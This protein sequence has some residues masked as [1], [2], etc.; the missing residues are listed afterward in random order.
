MKNIVVYSPS[1]FS[2]EIWL[3]TLWSQAKTYYELN[4]KQ[5]D[6]WHWYPCYADMYADDSTKVKEIIRQANPAVFAISLYV[7][8]AHT[9]FSIAKWVKKTFP[10]CIV[11][12]GG[13]Q[14]NFLYDATWFQK[15]PYIDA[16]LPGE[17]YGELF[18]QQLL[19]NYSNG[20]VDWNQVSDARYP[21]GASRQLFTSALHLG[22]QEKKQFDYNWPSFADQQDNID[23]FV[24]YKNTNFPS[25]KLLAV[26]ETTR[27]CPYG[28]TYCDW[29]GGIATTVIKK[30]KQSVD[31]DLEL[32][33]SLDLKY[34]YIA[35]ANFGIFGQRDVDIIQTLVHYRTQFSSNV[36]IGY[37]GFAKT[38][39]KMEYI[40]KILEIDLEHGL[41]SSN[42]IK[43]SLQSLD[44]EV[45]D[46][47]DRKNIPF[48]HQ[49]G[50]L[51]PLSQKNQLP[52]YVELILG[53][54]GMT[55][56][57]F[58]HELDVLGKYKLSIMWFEWLLLPETPA[59]N[60]AYRS[61]FGIGTTIK[62][63]GWHCAEPGSDKEIVVSC[64]SYTTTDYLQMLLSTSLYHAIVQGGLYSQSIA[65]S[66]HNI[67]AVVRDIYQNFLPTYLPNLYQQLQQD[68]ELILQNPEARC[69]FQID[70]HSV[71]GG[72]F[73]IALAYLEFD[74]FVAP[75]GN[76]LS[77][78]YSISA[79][80]IF[81]DQQ[82]LMH[83]HRSGSKWTGVTKLN[84]KKFN[85][86]E[87]LLDDFR[88]YRNSGH[89]MLAKKKLFGFIEV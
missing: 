77:T 82:A 67:G 12:S 24:N 88:L 69:E 7:W 31:Q 26:F 80:T 85:T 15:H 47:I 20:K 40:K 49:F 59:Y 64:N 35:D 11:V 51:Q 61:R 17:N 14:Q 46:N 81:Q 8:N 45:L 21:V 37:G 50:T 75:L 66:S 76:W 2:N 9:A 16:S 5:V 56:D 22:H 72:L 87:D 53:L 25:S 19:D 73:F 30:S 71:Y 48:E 74:Q 65:D 1:R 41:S 23:Q 52:L 78:R 58:Y 28:C 32:L 38:A 33:V 89:I 60:P 29:G 39:N 4:G 6:Q 68:W 42:E 86:V 62:Q 83:K 70:N 63:E 57:K 84:Y 3:P 36:V 79:K 10:Q 18:F 54:P 44:A 43:I 34:L 13:P 27:G 55:L